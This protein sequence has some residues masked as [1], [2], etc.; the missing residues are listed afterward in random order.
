MAQAPS[1]TA[2]TCHGGEQRVVLALLL[3]PVIAAAADAHREQVKLASAAGPAARWKA[4]HLRGNGSLLAHNK[5]ASSHTYPQDST[6]ST[7]DSASLEFWSRSMV[8]SVALQV[9]D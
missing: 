2:G 1:M 6:S 9:R 3:V 5:C 4:S 8:G 7:G